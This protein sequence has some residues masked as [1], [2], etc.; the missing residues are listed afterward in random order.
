MKI[1]V[2]G[3]RFIKGMAV[4]LA[5]FALAA[6]GGGKDSTASA[7]STTTPVTSV[8][9]VASSSQVY[10]GGDTVTI[11]AVV[12]GTG[13]VGLAS[14][15]VSFAADTGSISGAS[16]KTDSSGVAIATFSAGTDKT[17]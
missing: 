1:G 16:A 3:M 13:N 14:T 12:Q 15:A 11:T 4:L 9:V 17:N 5:G 6:C 8:S 2:N 10:T 7:T